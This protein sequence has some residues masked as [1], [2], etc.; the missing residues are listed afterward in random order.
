MIPLDPLVAVNAIARAAA[1]VIGA[2]LLRLRTL[3]LGAVMGSIMTVMGPLTAL[4]RVVMEL[5]FA[6]ILGLILAP[7]IVIVVVICIVWVG[8]AAMMGL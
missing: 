5:L 2:R 3:L 1:P 6:A 8:I 4:I 7:V